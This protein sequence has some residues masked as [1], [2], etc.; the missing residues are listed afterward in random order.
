MKKCWD[1]DPLKRPNSSE[2][3]NIITNWQNYIGR[4]KDINDENIISKESKNDI[5]E[6]YKKQVRILATK[7]H[8]KAYHMSHKFEKLKEI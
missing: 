7:P 3:L 6:F 5:I 8:P 2:I 4:D 1:K